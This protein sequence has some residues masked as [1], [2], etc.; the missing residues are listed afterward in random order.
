[1]T[2]KSLFFG[3]L[4]ALM[5]SG[6]GNSTDTADTPVVDNGK[7]VSKIDIEPSKDTLSKGATQQFTASAVYSDGTTQDVT[8]SSDS[9]WNTSDPSIATVTSS[10][11]ATA[12]AVGIVD[13][14]VNYKGVVA[15]E[16][17]AV[18]P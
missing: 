15:K 1:M 4:F 18:T 6:C 5:I 13:I 11:L 14:S 17:F 3:A 2:M 12:V 16:H 9:V 10:G 7:T 8:S